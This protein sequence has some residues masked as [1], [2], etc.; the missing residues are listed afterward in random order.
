MYIFQE[1]V[2]G[3]LKEQGGEIWWNIP[4]RLQIQLQRK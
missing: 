3:E 2:P 4:S 1:A